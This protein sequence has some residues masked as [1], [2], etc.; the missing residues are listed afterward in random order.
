MSVL[1]SLCQNLRQAGVDASV[2]TEKRSLFSQLVPFGAKSLGK[3][4]LKGRQIDEIQLFGHFEA[5]DRNRFGGGGADLE[6]VDVDYILH[7]D[8]KGK[9]KLLQAELKV[10]RT[11]LVHRKV[12]EMHWE[13]DTLA[14]RL[15]NDAAVTE[16][17]RQSLG[18]LSA[19]DIEVKL[20][21]D[22]GAAIIHVR[23]DRQVLAQKLPPFQMYEKIAEHIYAL[24]GTKQGRSVKDK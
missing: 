20:D 7:G 24:S 9:K 13:G 15:N 2:D 18:Q 3:I 12:V 17:L 19:R 6:A 4:I 11:G 14:D 10:K 1:E 22:A 23:D 21:E 8:I 16:L 5:E